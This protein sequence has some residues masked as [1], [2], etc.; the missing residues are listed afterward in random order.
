MAYTNSYTYT[1]S[2]PDTY[3]RAYCDASTYSDTY[4]Y[5]HTNPSCIWWLV[6]VWPFIKCG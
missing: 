6:E 3:A 5:P 2:H 1:G 4:S